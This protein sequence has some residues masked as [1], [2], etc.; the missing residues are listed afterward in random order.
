[1]TRVR[2][3]RAV[4]LNNYIE[5]ARFVGL[6]PYAMLQQ[7]SILPSQL[8]DPEYRLP[9]RAVRDL[10]TSS[11][12]SSGCESFALLLAECRTFASLGPLSLLLK[13]LPN[14][15]E[16]VAA[17]IE[18]QHHLNDVIEIRIEDHGPSVLLAT[19]FA[20][21]FRTR[22]VV[23]LSVA[24]LFRIL[25]DP[26]ALAWW[27]DCVHFR[28]SPP[29]KPRTHQ[30]VFACPIE[31][32]SGFDG[33][34][35]AATSLD[36]PNPTADTEMAEHARQLLRNLSGVRPMQTV[37]ERVRHTIYLLIRERQP[38]IEGAA[39]NMDLPPRTLQR[40][41]AREGTTF[42]RLL[43]ETRGELAL[44]YVESSDNPFIE[45]A[46]LT[47]Y[48]SHSAFTRWFANEFGEAPAARRNRSR[49]L[50]RNSTPD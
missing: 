6:D 7:V 41:L 42:G 36:V 21:T 47:G 1:V 37:S 22:E 46:H 14:G 4:S 44:R 34:S 13:H 49:G 27:P 28:H 40:R 50:A 11:A 3:V 15:R 31:F 32:N 5:V 9:A 38:T 8:A 33:I 29:A 10:L 20:P 45:V 17:I 23:E 24:M 26:L 18:H 43:N 30:R 35:C 2:Q 39:T 19:E 48:S 16:M 25:R 12:K